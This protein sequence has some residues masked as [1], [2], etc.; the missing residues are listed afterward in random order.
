MSIDVEVN[1]RIP[2]VKEPAKDDNGYPINSADV[3]FIRIVSVPALPKPDALLQLKMS[4]GSSIECAV[5]RADW[6]ESKERF[7]VYCTYSKKSILPDQYR[8]LLSDPDWEM[9]P[10]L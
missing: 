7:I 1:L 9:R 2:A 5:S 10:L 8:A 6:S 3:R 4:D